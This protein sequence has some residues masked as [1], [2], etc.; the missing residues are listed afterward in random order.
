MF[1]IDG[2]TMP[3]ASLHPFPLAHLLELKTFSDLTKTLVIPAFISG[4]HC[5]TSVVFGTS[6]VARF[7]PVPLG[8]RFPVSMNGC[9]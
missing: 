5:S 3:I 2:N 7:K 1:L 4:I 9:R 6:A 8:K